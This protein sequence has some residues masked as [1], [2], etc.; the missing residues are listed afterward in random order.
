MGLKEMSYWKDE[1]IRILGIIKEDLN[2]LENRADML[3]S[4]LETRKASKNVINEV[5][6]ICCE[7]SGIKFDVDTVLGIVKKE[8]Q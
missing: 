4:T 1:A 5:S 6:H 2:T 8:I 3:C 7:L